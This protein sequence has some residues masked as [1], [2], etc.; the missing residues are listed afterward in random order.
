MGIIFV[1]LNVEP[2]DISPQMD[3]ALTTVLQV[4]LKMK[5][6]VIAN[7]AKTLYALSVVYR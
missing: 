1:I 4:I 5:T 6:F 7:L 2:I 3:H